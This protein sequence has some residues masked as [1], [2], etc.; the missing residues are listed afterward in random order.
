MNI[1]EEKRLEH[2]VRGRPFVLEKIADL[3]F[4]FCRLA[5]AVPKGGTITKV[6]DLEGRKIATSYPETLQAW[7]TARKINA[8]IVSMSGAIEIA[9]RLDIADAI[10]DLVSTG[11]TL[12]A[13]G[14]QELEVIMKSQSI[15]VR[16]SGKEEASKEE[17]IGRIVSRVTGVLQAE[18]S[19]YIMLHCPVS[20]LE[21]VKA[22]L[23]G[24]E[25]PTILPLQ[26]VTDK[27]VLH[28]VCQ[29]TFFWETMEDLKAA[30]A[31]AV[32]VLPIEKMLN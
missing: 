23:P 1:F 3:G 26:G 7:L 31:T 11:E 32:L 29:E 6:A 8:A 20:A 10:C 14:L 18:D 9:P 22:A 24:V 5:I 15:L 16:R 27:V 30:G 25:S 4:G 21:T 28:A 19:K 17:L 2:K 12:A 13:N